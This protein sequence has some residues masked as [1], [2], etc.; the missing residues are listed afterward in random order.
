MNRELVVDGYN[1]IYAWPE[2]GR[3]MVAH[4]VEEA[5]R[6]LVTVLAGYAAS[7]GERVIVVFD[8][9]AREP[10][11]SDGE[12]IDGVTVI[13]GSRT[14]SADHVIERRVSVAARNGRAVDVTVAT[15]DH[16]QRDMVMAMGGS[17]IGAQALLGQVRAAESTTGDQSS[18]RRR[19]ARFANR[20]EHALDEETRRSL[21]RLRRGDAGADDHGETTSDSQPP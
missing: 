13:F 21:E 3:L 4:Q 11:P 7:T 18:R 8:A 16:L 10:G 12:S 20:L 1:I 19:E 14:Q 2:L 5:R 17:V 9:H 15:G 6:R